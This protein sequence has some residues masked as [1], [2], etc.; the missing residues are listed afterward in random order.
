VKILPIA[1]A[2]S[3][4]ANVFLGGFVAG[5]LHGGPFGAAGP[6]GGPP[7]MGRP[8]GGEAMT[9]LR[10]AAERPEIREKFE[11]RLEDKRGAMR[12]DNAEMRRLRS[13]LG[14]ALAAN[15]FVRADAEAAAAALA[16]FN[17]TREIRGVDFLIDV[18]EEL[19]VEDR[20]AI[21][22]KR[23]DT[24]RRRERRFRD[25]RER[26]GHDRPAAEE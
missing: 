7:P 11:R 21:I 10:A 4:A 5:R 3:L 2:L 15:P 19:P 9:L 22:E 16:A 25:R 20:R 13:A 8:S 6:G 1:L 12:A 26:A 23:E 24:Q 18:F 14:A 17:E